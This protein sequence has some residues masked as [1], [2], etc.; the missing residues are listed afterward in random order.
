MRPV[1]LPRSCRNPFH[2]GAR[3]GIPTT[4]P[5]PPRGVVLIRF[6]F[7]PR[8]EDSPA[9]GNNPA[10]SAP[11]QPRFRRPCGTGRK[12]SDWDGAH[13][14]AHA[15]WHD[16]EPMTTTSPGPDPERIPP[17]VPAGFANH[18]PRVAPS[19]RL[20]WGY[21]RWF[22]FRKTRRPPLY[23]FAAYPR[24]HNVCHPGRRVSAKRGVRP[25][26][27]NCEAGDEMVPAPWFSWGQSGHRKTR[28]LAFPAQTSSRL[29]ALAFL[30]PCPG[31]MPS[32]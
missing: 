21:V 16:E 5:L 4:L 22:R 13:G 31:S 19:L 28:G 10:S 2:T 12:Q 20:R 3:R 24:R 27:A 11:F 18:A 29:Q 23:R 7:F 1:F 14:V 32:S 26:A 6:H 30:Y 9:P 15:R 25:F 8:P 17:A